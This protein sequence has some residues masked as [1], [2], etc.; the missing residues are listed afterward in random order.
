[1]RVPNISKMFL[2]H[3]LC[4]HFLCEAKLQSKQAVLADSQGQRGKIPK[5]E[6]LEAKEVG[7]T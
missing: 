1:M 4:K 3:F 2:K 5:R 6:G 7:L